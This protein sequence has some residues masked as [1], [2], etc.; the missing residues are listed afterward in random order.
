MNGQDLVDLTVAKLVPITDAEQAANVNTSFVLAAVNEALHVV[1]R[2]ALWKWS[3]DEADLVT[4]IGQQE[5]AESSIANLATIQHIYDPGSRWEG[6]LKFL[7]ERQRF[8]DYGDGTGIPEA[9]SRW[10]GNIRLFPTPS[11]VRTLKVRY[12]SYWDD[13]TLGTEPVFP[14]IYHDMLADHAAATL[15]L[16][17]PPTGDRFLP[18]SRAEPHRQAFASKVQQMV[19]DPRSGVTMDEVTN[20]DWEDYVTYGQ[21]W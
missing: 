13:L 4:V 14:A 10:N 15:A 6:H 19:N 1:E 11:D 9:W 21:D 18:G 20:H 7:D 5:Y 2:M 3:E 16:R 12:Y 17:L 8:H